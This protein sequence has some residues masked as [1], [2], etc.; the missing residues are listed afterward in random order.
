M[1]L[2]GTLALF[3]NI[4]FILPRLPWLML[5]LYHTILKRSRTGVLASRISSLLWK[6]LVLRM[7][8]YAPL[9]SSILVT[10]LVNAWARKTCVKSS[11][12][13]KK[14]VLCS[15]PMKSIKRTSTSPGIVHS[16]ASRRFFAL[17]EKNIRMSNSFLSTRLQKAWLAN[18]VVAV[19]TWNAS[20]LTRVSWSSCT[21]LP[22]FLFA[23]M[24][25][26]KLWS[27][28]WRTLQ[29]PVMHLM[30]NIK[31]KYPLFMNLFVAEL[32]NLPTASTVLKVWPAMMPRVPCTSSLVSVYLLRPLRLPRMPS[33]ALT[34]SMLFK[35]WKPPAFALF[36]VRTAVIHTWFLF[37]CYLTYGLGSGFGQEAGTWHFRSTFL[38][39][40]HLFDDFCSNIEKF[41]QEFMLKYK[42]W[43]IR[44]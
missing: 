44:L 35:C 40:E 19:V 22:P 30:N 11:T 15:L 27:I 37:P 10:P 23:P 20:I 6:K 24:S 14:S 8:M 7:S 25:T 18:A 16:T 31:A 39:E 28:S 29:F 33:W 42:D 41:H 12:F 4:L 36:Q 3:L 32:A 38:P 34:H 9:W 1:I 21:R 13:A 2:T 26:A 43:D 5:L 17:W